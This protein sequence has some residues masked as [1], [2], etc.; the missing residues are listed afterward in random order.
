MIELYSI[1]LTNLF[2]KIFPTKIQLPKISYWDMFREHP[3]LNCNKNN[4][5]VDVTNFNQMIIYYVM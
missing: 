2:K 1:R 5:E 4:N 3:I